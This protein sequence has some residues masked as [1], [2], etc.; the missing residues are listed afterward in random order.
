MDEA[1]GWRIALR[2][3]AA[4][5]RRI[6]DAAPPRHGRRPPGNLAMVYLR[7]QEGRPAEARAMLEALHRSLRVTAEPT[8]SADRAVPFDAHFLHLLVDL[9]QD[10]PLRSEM[11]RSVGAAMSPLDRG[12]AIVQCSMDALA[13][14]I[15]YGE[16]RYDE[17]VTISERAIARMVN[18][19]APLLRNYL[20]LYLALAQIEM[21]EDGSAERTLSK[22]ITV[23]A[24]EAAA[25]SDIAGVLLAGLALQQGDRERARTLLDEGLVTLEQVGWFDVLAIGNE[26]ALALSSGD[27]DDER[28][29]EILL[30]MQAT[31]TRL[32]LSRL[33]LLAECLTVR[34]AITRGDLLAAGRTLQT[35]ALAKLQLPPL[36]RRGQRTWEKAVSARA[37]YAAATGGRDK[38]VAMLDRE[39][40]RLRHAKMPKRLNGMIE[41]RR[42]SARAFAGNSEE[43]KTGEYLASGRMVKYLPAA[44]SGAR[45]T[46]RETEVLQLLSEG[47]TSK[48]IANRLRI[49]EGTVRSY[50]RDLYCKFDVNSRS[51]VLSMARNRGLI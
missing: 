30:R 26:T 38:A 12:D 24:P 2:D 35:G 3:G 25:Q 49:A 5:L 32:Q 39:I 7:L 4:L 18:L 23:A 21:L 31:S 34:L 11:L 37:F 9:Y 43:S 46:S 6:E 45:L 41:Q 47:M 44:G 10:K 27:G 36:D 29:N 16:G 48:E 8:T 13:C 1:S 50:R 20:L 51:A 40:A 22:V 42:L 15:A 17:C 33:A 28:E 19:S 14:S